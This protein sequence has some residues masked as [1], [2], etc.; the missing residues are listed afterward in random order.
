MNGQQDKPAAAAAAGW[1]KDHLVSARVEMVPG[2]GGSC[3]ARRVGA[4]AVARG[5]AHEALSP[6]REIGARAP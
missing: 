6:A 5:S 1:Y 3:L 2:D 4:G